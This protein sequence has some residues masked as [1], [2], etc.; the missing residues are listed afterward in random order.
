M[1]RSKV[2]GQ[3]GPILIFGISVTISLCLLATLMVVSTSK[4]EFCISCHEMMPFYNTWYNGIH[5]PAKRGIVKAKC[6]DCHLP[7]DSLGHY[8]VAKVAYGMNDFWA[9]N[10][11]KVETLPETWIKEWEGI[12]PKAHK[13]YESGCRECHKSLVAPGI[14]LKAFSA[15]RAYELGETKKTC[16]SCHHMVGHGDLLTYMREKVKR[17]KNKT[18]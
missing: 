2:S 3:V 1:S 7:H 16:I 8:L 12:K 4:V 10:F 14:P 18:L 5:G 13:G 15:H 6:V 17:E 9:H 11:K